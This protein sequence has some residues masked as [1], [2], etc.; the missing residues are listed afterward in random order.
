MRWQSSSGEASESYRSSM[1]R[2]ALSHSIAS[3]TWVLPLFSEACESMISIALQ[4]FSD[5]KACS[6]AMAN[7]INGC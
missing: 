7:F 5:W 2:G 4:L 6:R 1:S 3:N